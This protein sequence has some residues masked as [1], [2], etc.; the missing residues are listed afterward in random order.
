MLKMRINYYGFGLAGDISQLPDVSVDLV[1]NTIEGFHLILKF[2]LINKCHYVIILKITKKFS[3]IAVRSLLINLTFRTPRGCLNCKG[4]L[5]IVW[6]GARSQIQ[7]PAVSRFL[8]WFLGPRERLQS[9]S[10]RASC[11]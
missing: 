4:V 2:S 11:D 1:V 3:K 7:F 5:G 9:I 8:G 6:L 10:P